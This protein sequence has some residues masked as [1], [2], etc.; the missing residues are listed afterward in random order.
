MTTIYASRQGYKFKVYYFLVYF[1]QVIIFS[2]KQAE[3]SPF[4]EMHIIFSCTSSKQVI[5][6][7]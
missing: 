3:Q 7:C 4:I 1:G 2:S 5:Q 6:E